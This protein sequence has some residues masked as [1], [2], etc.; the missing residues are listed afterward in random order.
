[1][2]ETTAIVLAAVFTLCCAVSAYFFLRAY[3]REDFRSGLWLKTVTSLFFTAAG[4]VLMM[5][6]RVSKFALLTV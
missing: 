3:R 1:M 2:S 6:G 4:V 5:R